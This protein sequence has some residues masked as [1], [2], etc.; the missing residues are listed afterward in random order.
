M[1]LFFSGIDTGIGKTTVVGQ[2]SGW[3]EHRGYGHITA[4]LVQTGCSGISED[5]VRHRELAGRP[6]LPEDRAGL[7]CPAVL[8]HPASPH[9]AARLAGGELNPDRL[10]QAIEA[11]TVRHELV[12]CE[13]AGGLEVPLTAT[14]SILDVLA[15]NQWPL[16]LV[17]SS[18]LGSISQTRL[19]L[20]AARSAGLTVAGIVYNDWPRNPDRLV[21]RD[22]ETLL[23]QENPD[24]AWCTVDGGFEPLERWLAN[25]RP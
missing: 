10:A 8:P 6:L 19:S 13:G 15:Q 12:L 24:V 9:L 25:R 22:T 11:L 4:K 14:V 3:L 7:T 1:V 21:A 5:I 20:R 23:R 2:F 18:R 16:V 17:T